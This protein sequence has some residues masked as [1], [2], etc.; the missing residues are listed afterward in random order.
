MNKYLRGLLATLAAVIIAPTIVWAAMNLRQDTDGR[1]SFVSSAGNAYKVGRQVLSA[2]FADIATAST[3]FVAASVDGQITGWNSVINNAITT[4]NCT[5]T[6]RYNDDW[7]N[8]STI[9]VTQASSAAGD[10][11]SASGLTIN[12]TAGG[13]I[14]IE[15]DGGCD[16]TTVTPIQ[17]FVDGR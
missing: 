8:Q 5:L 10:Y 2:Q 9:T 7:V 6:L 3:V 13:K 17:V 12:V 14:R 1:A 4:A 11:D 16:T 15:S